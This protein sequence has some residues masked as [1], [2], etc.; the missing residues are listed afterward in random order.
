MGIGFRYL[1]TLPSGEPADPAAFLTTIPT[2]RVGDTFL[3]GSD[4][5]RF[6][7]LAVDPNMSEDAPGWDALFVVQPVVE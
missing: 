1:L 3:A 7:I 5:H 2:W 6:R 4:L